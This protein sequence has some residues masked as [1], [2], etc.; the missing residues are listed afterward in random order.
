M[1]A[2]DQEPARHGRLRRDRRPHARSGLG[3][4]ELFLEAIVEGVGHGSE[5]ADHLLDLARVEPV[6]GPLAH[7]HDA[8]AHEPEGGVGQARRVE[9]EQ[10]PEERRVLSRVGRKRDRPGEAT[11]R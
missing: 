10:T 4:A 8:V 3:G 11:R 1:T 7:G 5:V 9:L 2:Q 6:G